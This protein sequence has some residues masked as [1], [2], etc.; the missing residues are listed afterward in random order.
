MSSLALL[1]DACDAL[2]HTTRAMFGGHGLFAPNGGMFAAVVDEDRIALKL[3]REVDQAAF[4]AL[5]GKPWSYQDRMTMRAWLV[6]PEAMY[7]E[8]TLLAK[9]CGVAHATAEPKKAKK[10]A[11]KK[12][13]VKSASAKRA[14]SK[15]SRG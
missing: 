13:G 4:V 6:I 10:G 15:D 8:P 11:T 1:Q 3:P 12:S 7:D 14:G 9:W 2:P 5:G